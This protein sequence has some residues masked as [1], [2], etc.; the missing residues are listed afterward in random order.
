MELKEVLLMDSAVTL[1]LVLICFGVASVAVG[2]TIWAVYT[3][4]SKDDAKESE[5]NLREMLL[6]TR[7]ELAHDIAGL[8][9][10]L[11]SLRNEYS[12][13]AKDISY[14]RGRLEPKP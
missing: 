4:Q 1:Q 13:M 6:N 10:D 8:S 7:V 12:S 5:K 14:I 3:F 2:I 11:T 9:S